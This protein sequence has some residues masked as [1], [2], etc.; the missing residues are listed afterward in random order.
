VARPEAYLLDP[1]RY[2]LRTEIGVR[3]SDLDLNRHL[4]NVALID[5]LQDARGYFHRASG[6]TRATPDFTLMVANLNVQFLGEGAFGDPVVCHAGLRALGR[7]SQVVAQLALQ[8][9]QPIAYA[10]TVMVT[11][12]DGVP[13]PHPADYR[14]ALMPWLIAP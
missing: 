13:G 11:M 6:M 10:E 4:N 9:D 7:T 1:G 14:E 2:H 8:A 5:I 3:F 12:I